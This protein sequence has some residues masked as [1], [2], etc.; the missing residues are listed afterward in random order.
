V[1]SAVTGGRTSISNEKVINPPPPAKALI[2][3]ATIVAKK[4]KK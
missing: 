4:N 3:P 2:V 1:A